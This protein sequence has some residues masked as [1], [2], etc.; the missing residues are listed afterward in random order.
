MS[1]ASAKEFSGAGSITP[2]VLLGECA[3][4][5]PGQHIL[6]HNYNRR[7]NGIGYLTGPADFGQISPV[8]CRWTNKPKAWATPG[9]VLVTVKGAGVGKS[10]LAPNCKVAIGR[11]LMAI[12]PSSALD[13]RYL[14]LFFQH[15]FDDFQKA[16]LGATVPGLGRNDIQSLGIP[17]PPM[18]EQERI[19][20]RLTEQLAIVE[21]ARAAAQA[22]LAAAQALPAAYLREVFEGPLINNWLTVPIAEVCQV[23]EGQVD[24]R[25]KQ[26]GC[27]PH[28]N[29]EN[30]Q[31]GTGRILE[32]RTAS[33]DGLIS[34]KYLFEP[35]MVLYSKLR[36][37][38]RKVAIAPFRGV[39]SADMYPLSF[40]PAKVDT[41]FAMWSLLAGPFTRYAVK[42][43]E[44]ARMPKL[45]REQLFAWELSLPE[46][47][48]E[49][50]RI[51][52]VLTRS[53]AE[54]ERLAAR[55]RDE[56]AAIDALPAAL[57][58]DAFVGQNG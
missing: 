27:L 37:Y 4:I 48:S 25:E 47:V 38:L 10:N 1:A 29:G 49:Q 53:L 44:R 23:V 36:P 17:L 45:N 16:A 9:D 57:L 28:I 2:I 43:S 39:C 5:H 13:Q 33:Q 56:L 21:R 30:I 31:S 7:G 22:R 19:A 18:A 8:I 6:E 50:Q 58:R 35:G 40:D 46:D 42:E 26:Y 34:G 11:Q 41:T 55:I 12:R 20:G 32:V 15:V 14:H 52:A 51:A 54:A 3:T 24:P